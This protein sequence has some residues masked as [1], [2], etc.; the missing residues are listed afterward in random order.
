MNSKLN[1]VE[2]KCFRFEE[3]EKQEIRN[4]SNKIILLPKR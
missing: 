1:K 4:K 2:I 3:K